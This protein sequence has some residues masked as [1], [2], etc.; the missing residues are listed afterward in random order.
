LSLDAGDQATIIGVGAAAMLVLIPGLVKAANFR[1]DMNK[2]WSSRIDLAAVALDEKTVVALRR[3]RDEIS[4]ALPD[5]NTPFRPEEAILDPSPLVGKVEQTS[6]YYRSRV[7]MQKYLNTLLRLGR[8]AAAALAILVVMVVLVTLYYSEL[9]HV[10]AVRVIGLIGGGIALA[11]GVA[12]GITYYI[13]VEGL[14]SSEILADTASQ[15]GSEG[16]A[17]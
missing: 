8:V 16:G 15:A 14:A 11:A 12:S 10:G 1:G 4:N 7:R 2:K 6:K 17:A 5:G 13:C 3:L 9:W